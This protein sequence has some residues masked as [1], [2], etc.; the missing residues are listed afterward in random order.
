MLLRALPIAN[1]DSDCT[2]L[3][4][5]IAET[6]KAE[7]SK[8]PDDVKEL[9]KG[10][11]AGYDKW[12]GEG[13]LPAPCADATWVKPIDEIDLLTYFLDLALRGSAVAVI[14]YVANAEPPGASQK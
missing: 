4:L 6:A 12:V 2:Y 8:Q 10:Y 13:K 7:L 9:V 3:Q 1:V 11:V 14:N 5:G